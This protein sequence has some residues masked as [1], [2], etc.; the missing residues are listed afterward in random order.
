MPGNRQR[1][2]IKYSTLFEFKHSTNSRE[3]LL[4]GIGV[5]PLAKIKEDVHA[6]LGC[7]VETGKRARGVKTGTHLGLSKGSAGRRF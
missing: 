2:T 3:S 7:H 5:L 4:S 1:P 6:L